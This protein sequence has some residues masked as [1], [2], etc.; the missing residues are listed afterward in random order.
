MPSTALSIGLPVTG[1]ISSALSAA[2]VK[3]CL[4][5]KA[6]GDNPLSSG[7]DICPKES[8]LYSISSKN[9]FAK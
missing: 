6:F 2:P 5:K 9:I 8:S 3:P 1:I 7:I 4:K